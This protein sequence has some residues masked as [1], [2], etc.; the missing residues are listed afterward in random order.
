MNKNI[1]IVLI[2]VIIW[3][4]VAVIITYFVHEKTDLAYSWKLFAGGLFASPILLI[5]G[6]VKIIIDPKPIKNFFKKWKTH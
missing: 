3:I 1:I 6:L 2:S 5:M 4:V